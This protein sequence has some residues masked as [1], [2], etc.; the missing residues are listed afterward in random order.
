M[1]I[2]DVISWATFYGCLALSIYL[3][4]QIIAVGIILIFLVLFAIKYR[5][6]ESKQTKDNKQDN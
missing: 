5:E 3:K 4:L 1:K 2:L 6:I